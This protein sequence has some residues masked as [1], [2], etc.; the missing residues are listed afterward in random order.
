LT[1]VVA[2]PKHPTLRETTLITRYVDFNINAG[3]ISAGQVLLNWQ[4]I[5][6]NATTLNTGFIVLEHD[7]FEQCVDLATGY[8]LPDALAYTP[9]FKIQPVIECLNK[10]LSDAY[11]E[12]NDNSSSPPPKDGMLALELT[13]RLLYNRAL[14]PRCWRLADL[15]CSRLSTG[16]RS[17]LSHAQRW[18]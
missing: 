16:H 15:S 13:L 9:S 17:E 5:L 11:V 8:I 12:T 7:L 1:P 10:P 2:Q 3:T 6:G 18:C 14:C 4:Q